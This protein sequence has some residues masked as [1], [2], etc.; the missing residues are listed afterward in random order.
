MNDLTSHTHG[1]RKLRV[2]GEIFDSK[3]YKIL[4]TI[5]YATSIIFKKTIV[6]DGI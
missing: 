4:F 5:I 6:K 3:I 2:G 1:G